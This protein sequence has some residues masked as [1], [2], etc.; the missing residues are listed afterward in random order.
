MPIFGK[1]LNRRENNDPDSVYDILAELVKSTFQPNNQEG[2]T[3]KRCLVI[4]DGLRISCPDLKKT[5]NMDVSR[6]QR[7]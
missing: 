2:R 3:Q 1:L 6:L 4:D 7:H 5:P